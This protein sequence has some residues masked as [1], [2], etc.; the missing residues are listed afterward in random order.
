MALHSGIARISEISLIY[1][2]SFHLY[3]FILSDMIGAT[4][5]SEGGG[6]GQCRYCCRRALPRCVFRVH[7]N[8]WRACSPRAYRA[9]YILE[10][11][12]P[13]SR[14]Q[15]CSTRPSPARALDSARLLSPTAK[16]LYTYDS[17]L[18]ARLVVPAAAT[19]RTVNEVYHTE[20]VLTDRDFV[21]IN[22]G[23]QQQED[24]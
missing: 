5:H 22:G 12:N 11:S 18:A 16:T 4:S 13:P 6:G 14:R 7:T 19:I 17:Y 1:F 10:F 23:Y 15:T 8:E 3:S 2:T 20:T 9:L 24:G 21:R